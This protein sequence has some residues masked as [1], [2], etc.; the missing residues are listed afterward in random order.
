LLLIPSGGL[1]I[2]TP[3]LRE[4]V[5]WEADAGVDAVFGDID[6]LGTRC[7]FDDC[8]HRSEPG[9]AVRAAIASGDLD[10]A[11]LRSYEKM[12]RERDFLTGRKRERGKQ[13]AKAARH[14]RRLGID[15]AR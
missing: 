14:R 15:K 10:P 3:G 9:C 1:V 11:R 4:L 12:Q 5:A 13:I 7:R 2:D 6:E 8:A